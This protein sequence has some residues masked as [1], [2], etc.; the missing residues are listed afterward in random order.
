MRIRSPR[1][2]IF[3]KM[4]ISAVLTAAISLSTL[5][6]VSLAE[7]ARGSVTVNAVVLPLTTLNVLKRPNE[8]TVTRADVKR[9]YVRVPE[10]FLIELNNNTREGCLLSFE[11]HGLPFQGAAVDVMGR[12]ILLGPEGGQVLLPVTGRITI[13]LSFRFIL[14]KETQPGTYEWPFSLSINPLR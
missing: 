2:R 8:L 10:A 14:A 4:L 7:P 12:D 13:S 6:A 1:G 9:G 3:K 11:A 5:P